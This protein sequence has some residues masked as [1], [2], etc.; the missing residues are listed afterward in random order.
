LINSTGDRVNALIRCRAALQG[1]PNEI[2]LARLASEV[3]KLSKV[4]ALNTQ[5]NDPDGR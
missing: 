2:A 1:N 4:A 5:E 3:R